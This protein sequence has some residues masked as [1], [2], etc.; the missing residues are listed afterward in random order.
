[1]NQAQRIVTRMMVPVCLLAGSAACHDLVNL[2][3]HPQTFV[4]PAGYFKTG[5]QAIDAVNGIYNALMTWD[6]W[7]DPA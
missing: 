3:E 5:A 4:D 6:D 1:M 7:I 2:D